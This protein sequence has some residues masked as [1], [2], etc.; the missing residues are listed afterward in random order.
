QIL[1]DKNIEHEEE[2]GE[3]AFYGPKI[4]FK[5]KDVIGR[6]R[7]LSTVQFDFNLPERFDMTFTNDKGEQERPFMIHRALLGSLER[8]MGVLIENYAGAFPMRLAPEQIKIL[9]VADKFN[10]YAKKVKE[11]LVAK[12]YRASIDVS[13]DSFSKKIRNGEINKIPYLFIV[14][15]K[16]ETDNTISRRS[17]KTKEQGTC[18]IEEFIKSLD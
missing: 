3:A 18:S 5:V 12:G 16:E 9:A 4:D 11:N 7:Q 10:D 17:Y 15:E 8:F 1:K 6:E 2:L 14:G 13:S